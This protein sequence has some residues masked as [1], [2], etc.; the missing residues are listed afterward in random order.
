M[1]VEA[2]GNS[3]SCWLM[4]AMGSLE[5]VLFERER[6]EEIVTSLSAVSLG[7]GMHVCMNI[8]TF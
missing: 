7:L 1:E 2:W 8:M 4:H 5:A 6:I 3:M